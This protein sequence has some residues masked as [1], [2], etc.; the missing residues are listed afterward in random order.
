VLKGFAPNYPHADRQ[1]QSLPSP[2]KMAKGTGTLQALALATLFVNPFLV[3]S[4]PSSNQTTP[5][6][7]SCGSN[8]YILSSDD[9]P[10]LGSMPN[11]SYI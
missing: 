6:R 2:M 7:T 11:L 9:N 4:V 5:D 10:S 8:L 3:S 1:I